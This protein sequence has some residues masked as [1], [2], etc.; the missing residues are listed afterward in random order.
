MRIFSTIEAYFKLTMVMCTGYGFQ[1]PSEWI[2]SSATPCR[3]KQER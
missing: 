2:L 1:K 3:F